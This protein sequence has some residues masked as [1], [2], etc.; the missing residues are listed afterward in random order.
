M[1]RPPKNQS[2]PKHVI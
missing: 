2:P 1:L